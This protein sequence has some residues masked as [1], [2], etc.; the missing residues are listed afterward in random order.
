M[1]YLLVLGAAG[2][3]VLLLLELELS[4]LQ[5]ANTPIRPNNTI[6]VNNLFIVA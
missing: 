1:S 5:P 6:K 2:A 4:W 3:F